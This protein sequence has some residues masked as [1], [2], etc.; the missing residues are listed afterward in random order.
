MDFI[1]GMLCQSDQIKELLTKDVLQETGFGFT[2]HD[3][4]LYQSDKYLED[5]YEFFVMNKSISNESSNGIAA[6]FQSV[7]LNKANQF[8]NNCCNEDH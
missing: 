8:T 5:I 3:L 1:A 7:K 4:N 6:I 2:P